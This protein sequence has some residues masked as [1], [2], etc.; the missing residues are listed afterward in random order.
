MVTKAVGKARVRKTPVRKTPARKH[1]GGD[2]NSFIGSFFGNDD[3]KNVPEGVP[4]AFQGAPLS[5]GGAKRGR[6]PSK[7]SQARTPRR[8]R[9]IKIPSVT[10]GG[11]NLAPYLSS[12]ILLGLSI[13]NG[14]N[15]KSKRKYGG[16]EGCS[17]Q[18]AGKGPS[19]EHFLSTL[20]FEGGE[21]VLGSKSTQFAF[22]NTANTD[23]SARNYQG[24]SDV[25]VV[26][27][28][29]KGRKRRSVSPKRTTVSRKPGRK[30]KGGNDDLNVNGVT[31]EV[32]V[33]NQ[34]EATDK[35]NTTSGLPM[36]TMSPVPS[37]PSGQDGGAKRRGRKPTKRRSPS[38]KRRQGGNLLSD[39]LP[40]VPTLGGARRGRKKTSRSKSP[41]RRSRSPVRRVRK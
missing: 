18:T 20:R 19:L 1:K 39:L 28:A 15:W 32:A 17:V 16:A 9:I 29:R 22:G 35:M 36:D 26:G 13:A 41:S 33:S 30:Y 24:L 8:R 10:K 21:P 11:N 6:K 37:E 7:P 40:M 2:V 34:A 23:I 3:N 25:E 4:E 5:T 27:G 31:S 38:P 14:D 12:L